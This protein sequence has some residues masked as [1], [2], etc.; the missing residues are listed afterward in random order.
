[1]EQTQLCL[2]QQLISQCTNLYLNEQLSVL[3][4]LRFRGPG[5]VWKYHKQIDKVLLVWVQRRVLVWGGKIV[6]A[7]ST[8]ASL[9]A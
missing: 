2:F 1:M 3:Q 4:W 8:P 6:P 9:W 7:F 5:Q